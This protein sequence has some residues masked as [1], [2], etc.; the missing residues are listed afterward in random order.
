MSNLIKNYK[1]LGHKEFVSRWQ[2]GIQK[3][4]PFQ[5][6][7]FMITGNLIVI[8]GVLSGLITTA[9]TKVWWLFTILL[10]SAFIVT[11]QFIA[12]MQKYYQLKKY[13]ELTP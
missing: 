9:I 13:E 7:K 4:T 11:T 10:G 3:T 8:V 5:Q 12:T 2:K 1:E 6:T